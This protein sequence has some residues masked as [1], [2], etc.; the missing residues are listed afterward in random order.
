[1]T[2]LVFVDVDD[3]LLTPPYEA[4][5]KVSTFFG[6]TFPEED[7]FRNRSA[8]GY[9]EA[10]PKLFKSPA[11]MWA[12]ALLSL[13]FGHFR[14]QSAMPF[15]VAELGKL[16]AD[17]RLYLVSKNPPS[18]TRWRIQRL[19]EIFGVDFGDRYIACGPILKKGQ[20][21]LSIM[22]QVAADRHVALGDCLL[23]DDSV[24]NLKEAAAAGVQCALVQS[25]WNLAD[26]GPLQA[27][28]PEMKVIE[29]NKISA[30]LAEHLKDQVQADR[31]SYFV[32]PTLSIRNTLRLAWTFVQRWWLY[33][34][35]LPRLKQ[36]VPIARNPLTSF[37]YSDP[38]AAICAR[39]A[40]IL[41]EPNALSGIRLMPLKG[42]R[43]P[44]LLPLNLQHQLDA[45]HGEQ[46]VRD[47]RTACRDA[48]RAKGHTFVRDAMFYFTAL[49]WTAEKKRILAS[50]RIQQAKKTYA[51]THD[52]PAKDIDVLASR[53]ADEL[54]TCRSYVSC[55]FGEWVLDT[56][57]AKII[58]KTHVKSHPDIHKL[59]KDHFVF[60]AATHRSYLD[61]AVLWSVLSHNGQSFPFA[62]G[63]DKMK[64]VWFGKLGARGGTFFLRRKFIDVIYAAT[65]AEHVAI[66]QK[67]GSVLE[68]FLE[69]QRSRSG[70][71]L[72]PKKGIASI[73]WENMEPDSKVAIVPVSFTYNKI[74]ES[75]KIIKERFDER[76]KLGLVT[77]R[78][79]SDMKIRLNRRKSRY[80]GARAIWR[81]LRSPMVSECYVYFAEPILLD[82]TAAQASLQGHVNEA[83]LRI[84]EATAVLPSSILCLCLLGA[85]EGHTTFE[86]AAEF[87]QFS[88]S[89]VALY[90]LPAH[91]LPGLMSE[92]P[93]E[94]VKAFVELPFVNRKFK[95]A[96]M[97]ER[98]I[99]C[100]DDLDV[101][102]ASYYK[103]N[104][105]HFFV[106]PAILSY[107]LTDVH[108]GRIEELHRCFDHMFAKLQA[109]YFLPRVVS[110]RSFIDSFLQ[111]LAQRGLIAV[112]DNQWVIND[113]KSNA[114]LMRVLSRMGAELVQ[115]DLPNLLDAIRRSSTRTDVLVP[116]RLASSET[117]TCNQAKA[118]GLSANEYYLQCDVAAA[119]GDQVAFMPEGSSAA[120][121]GT[122]AKV[123]VDG[124][125][126]RHEGF[127]GVVDTNDTAQL[128]AKM[129]APATE[130]LC[131]QATFTREQAGDGVIENLSPSGAFIA[132]GL[133]LPVGTRLT[134]SLGRQ[135][136]AFVV[137]SRVARV[138][139]A[140]VGVCFEGLNEEG[141]AR[142]V[143]L[144]VGTPEA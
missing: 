84:N 19:K 92:D 95:R 127:I 74:P 78:E 29:T 53:Y 4:V 58:K 100:I 5:K 131:G 71:T 2:R 113:Q 43:R 34:E 115:G 87:L 101:E 138:T 42:D 72:P 81:R 35:P 110:T 27:A 31:T 129:A 25:S 8:V 107:V 7:L 85:D 125:K 96:Q 39:I 130:A 80:E 126:V 86:F 108:S 44:S 122:V 133:R 77:L 48:F 23:V 59:E 16:L 57:L 14:S 17:H 124:V 116:S 20:S 102:R 144:S 104:V 135:D 46:K 128:A 50:A 33:A 73:V 75:E 24:E 132:T 121:R 79:A 22:K 90:Q 118:T 83:M 111:I 136:D 105:L 67:P 141:K 140:G 98:E 51:Q 91:L 15:D 41:A 10:F 1:M 94:D 99:L 63:A 56:I 139:E 93:Q 114:M 18:F 123:D 30:A 117:M 66:M 120:V 45:A 134:C 76:Q 26:I 119:L 28:F 13:P 88:K 68:V 52:V 3:T 137:R 143:L 142:I 64:K 32:V 106:L 112:A 37:F 109:T 12:I 40:Q 55:L 47:F 97:A 62:V 38:H 61:S 65:I 36:I 103:N 21:K 70:L 11:E 49:N 60:Y 82:K 54:M 9:Y 6:K 89:V 69:G